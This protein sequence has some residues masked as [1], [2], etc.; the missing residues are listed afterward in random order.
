M[1]IFLGGLFIR[2]FR[3]EPKL[4]TTLITIVELI[5]FMGIFSA[6]FLGC[7]ASQFSGTKHDE[8]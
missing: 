8:M 1:G 6:I 2:Q 7:P 4:L 3:P 5:G